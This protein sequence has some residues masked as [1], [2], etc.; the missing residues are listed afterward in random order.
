MFVC[1]FFLLFLSSVVT[2]FI[3][4]LYVRVLCFLCSFIH[5]LAICTSSFVSFSTVFSLGVFSSIPLHS[6]VSI[7]VATM[8]CETICRETVALALKNTLNF[9]FRAWIA[10]H[11]YI[12]THTGRHSHTHLNEEWVISVCLLN[13][14][15]NAFFSFLP[16]S[17][18]DSLWG[19]NT[20]R[21]FQYRV[22]LVFCG[23]ECQKRYSLLSC[24][25]RL[26][27]CA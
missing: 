24:V 6:F 27:Q 15:I 8:K 10:L 26:A 23:D 18:R 7:S 9:G 1:V 12:H 2:T 22:W 11:L 25:N 14:K 17:F 13:H 5:S 4:R 20:H 21:Q 16:L 3:C 19:K